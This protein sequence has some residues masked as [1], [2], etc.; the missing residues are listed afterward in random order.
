MTAPEAMQV[1]S[2]PL[3]PLQYINLYTDENIHRGRAPKPPPPAHDSY[4][5]FGNVFNADDSI[6]RPLEA[7]G[8]K[9]L[10]P[11]HFDR[12]RELKKLN[13]SLLVNFLD[14][15]DLLVQSPDSPRRAEKVEDLSLLFIH[16]H[17]LLNEFRPHQARETLRVMMELQRRQRLETSLRFQKH[18]EKVQQILQH[19]LQMLPDTS[20]LDSKLAINI[21]AMESID[22]LGSEQ[23]N[24]DTCSQSDRIMC[25]TIDDMIASN[26]LF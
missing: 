2:L 22:T 17:H 23:Q 19:A 7:Q 11:Q 1:S 18:L 5:M 6:I 26:N 24:M 21:D 20:E 12:R 25:K 3:P 4:S 8:I 14:L 16:I 9:R 15:I 10:Y 13:H